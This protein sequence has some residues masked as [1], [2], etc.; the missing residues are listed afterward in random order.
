M[1][2]NGI[3]E[4]FEEV[5]L[6]EEYDGYFCSVADVITIMILGSICGLKNVNQIHQWAA[7]D[8]VSE[9]LKEEFGI[10]HVP[11]YYWILCLLHL[12]KPE[13]LNC[14]FADLVYSF[15]P[16]KS[17]NMTISLDGKTICSTIKM[18]KIESPLHII[19]AQVCEMGLTLAQRCTDDKSNEIPAVQ[20]L[21]RELNIKGHII[22]ADALNCQKETAG[23]IVKQKADYLLCVKD[24]HPNLKKDIEDFIQDTLLQDTIQSVSKSEK[25][26]G[27]IEKRTAF[28]TS[29]IQWLEQRKEWKNLKCMGAVHTEITTKNGTSGEWHYCI[30]SLKINRTNLLNQ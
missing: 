8:R 13:S 27:R 20:E 9:F 23:I 29:D 28:V 10:S 30:V 22:V 3:T 15:M 11:C 19:S 5:E 25:N 16:E 26:R 14:C 7:S 18:K 12:I 4:Y 1:K 17:K 21:L 24:N 2:N 6:Y